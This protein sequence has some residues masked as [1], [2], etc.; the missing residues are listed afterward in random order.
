MSRLLPL[1]VTTWVKLGGDSEGGW[2]TYP[3]DLQTT[4][5]N[6]VTLTLI[7]VTTS[8]QKSRPDQCLVDS[9][10]RRLELPA[11]S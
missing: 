11:K 10:E 4:W 9:E 8:G 1:V 3:S 6:V 2:N 5:R 7:I